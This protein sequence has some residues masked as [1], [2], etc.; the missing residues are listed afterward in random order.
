MGRPKLL[1]PWGQTTVLGHLLQRWRRLQAKQIGVV[2]AAG[3]AA[4]SSELERINFPKE[5]RILNPDPERGMFSS[6]R[7]A[8]EWVGWDAGLTHWVITLGDQPQL[9]E[10][11]LSELLGFGQSN[12]EKICQPMRNG[13]RK[14]PVL[15]P[16]NIFLQLKNAPAGDL[17]VFLV[18]RAGALSGFES[19]DEG[20]DLDMDTPEDYERVW[21]ATFGGDPPQF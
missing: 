8:A 19:E 5:N 3:A 12:P 13:R 4:L 11:T 21:R 6:I 14:H 7:C 15:L 1:L 10:E 16:K 2:C 20:L 9:R 18:E 17:K